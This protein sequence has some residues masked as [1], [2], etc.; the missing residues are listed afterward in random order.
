MLEANIEYGLKHPE[1]KDGLK[2][3]LK[4]LVETL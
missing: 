2:E 4:A 3:Y 1:I